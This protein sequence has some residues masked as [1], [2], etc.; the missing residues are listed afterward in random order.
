[1]QSNFVRQIDRPAQAKRKRRVGGV[2]LAGL[3]HAA[4]SH[5]SRIA[6]AA[7]FA[8]LLRY[9]GCRPGE[10]AR[11]RRDDVS[12]SSETLV[13]RNTKFK[14]EDRSIHLT[15]RA[16]SILNAQ[17]YQNTV[18][19]VESEY[20]F[21]TR[22]KTSTPETPVYVYYNY[23]SA[24]KLLRRLGV[25]EQSFHAHAMRREYISRAI[26]TNMPYSTIKKLTGHHSSQAIEIYDEG[27]STAPE[28]RE[29]LNRHEQAINE[30]E[31]I[32]VLTRMGM[33]PQQ[34]KEAL[35]KARGE[36][37]SPMKAVLLKE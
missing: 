30:D 27:L 23:E 35:A 10:L 15:P 36:Y 19:G 4:Q 3:G 25:V 34:V 24:I 7:R 22:A 21:S 17:F 32:G 26:E 20:V 1:M 16:V 29:A 28:I 31:L 13:F 11:L 14:S 5:D 12:L 37:V 2:E 18:E 33:S 9:A 6:E 8:L